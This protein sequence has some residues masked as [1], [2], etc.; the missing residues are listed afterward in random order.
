MKAN[1]NEALSR[2]LINPLI[3]KS[4]WTITP[5]ERGGQIN[6]KLE[7]RK[8][9]LDKENNKKI[10]VTDYTFLDEND[11]PLMLLEAKAGTY[12]PLIAKK[13]ARD[14]ANN[15]KINFIILSN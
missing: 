2:A 9:L 10:T 14:Y 13:Q 3:E 12:D 5:S 6:V 8:I 4:G 7:D 11:H 15:R 1:E